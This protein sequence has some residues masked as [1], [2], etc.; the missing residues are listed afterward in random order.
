VGVV[1]CRCSNPVKLVFLDL[2]QKEINV[3]RAL[4]HGGLV[5]G[6]VN[7][8]CYSMTQFDTTYLGWCVG[9]W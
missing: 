2:V 5:K 9:C 1:C 8:Q 4:K 3:L 7:N 6:S